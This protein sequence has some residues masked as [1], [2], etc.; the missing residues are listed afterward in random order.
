MSIVCEEFAKAAAQVL[1]WHTRLDWDAPTVHGAGWLIQGSGRD[2]AVFLRA[3]RGRIQMT[4]VF[5]D[6]TNTVLIDAPTGWAAHRA[7]VAD[8]RTAGALVGD[9]VRK[10]RPAYL[11]ALGLAREAL[12]RRDDHDR[13]TAATHARLV[14][15]CGIPEERRRDDRIYLSG[16]MGRIEAC[17][18]SV[19]F[20]HLESV[21]LEKAERIIAILLEGDAS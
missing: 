7:T 14:E 15:L 2:E 19:R 3:G 18:D 20:D 13:L 16:V 9:W 12:D 8:H 6:G 11:Y 10:C 5:P 4:G 21:P 1:H 17:G